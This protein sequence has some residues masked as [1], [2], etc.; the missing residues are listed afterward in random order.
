[1]KRV[2]A[3]GQAEGAVP[4]SARRERRVLAAAILMIGALTDMI[5]VSIV[6]V[7]LPTIGRRLH[8]GATAL[9]WIVSAYMVGFSAVLIVAGRLGDR[10]GRRKLFLLGTL[11]F[12]AASLV[13][14]LSSSTGLLITARA[15]Q[16]VCA[17]VMTPQV[18]ATFREI[19]PRSQRGAIFGV[20]GAVLGL[21][22]A[23]GVALGG[24]LVSPSALG[25]GWRSIFLINVPI[26][27]VAAVGALIVVPE[28]TDPKARRPDPI[29]ATSLTAGVVA[30][31]FALL[32]GRRLN[33]PAWNFCLLAAGL[34]ALLFAAGR[35]S[36]KRPGTASIVP[37]SLLAHRAAICGL[38]TQL[39][40]SAGLQGLMLSFALFLQAGQHATPLRAGL[41]L[42]AFS[43]GGIVSAP[44]AAGLAERYGR[45]VLALGALMLVAGVLG[46]I[47][48]AHQLGTGPG[49]WPLIP[50]L[51]VAGAG[52]GLLVVPLVN[53]VLAAVPA[54]DA[55]GASG[56]FSTSQQLGG[57]L[58]V[59]IIGTVFFGHAAGQPTLAAFQAAAIAAGGAFALC[60]ALT[61][62]L[63][64]KALSEEDVLELEA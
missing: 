59:A 26:A 25:L 52:L 64:R 38:A 54:S 18:L 19:F 63:P 20:Y 14:G 7:A 11:G 40:F 10:Y 12:G 51:V 44:Q 57:A 39:V 22:S 35:G 33:W 16:G 48:G 47:V 4:R 49:P 61:I 2:Y 28:S 29:G 15:I 36:N 60:G 53:V 6:N 3:S 55:G 34:L 43:A 31:V 45:R 42:L 58:G 32:E 17:G 27:G 50:G 23:V 37:T 1:M 13:A 5:D 41:T 8:A 62:G 46:M 21:A 56:V 9:E 30:V 24:V